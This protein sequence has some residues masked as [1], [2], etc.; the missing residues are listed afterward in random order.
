MSRTIV[1]VCGI[2]RA[3]DAAYAIACGADW[4]GFVVKAPGSPRAIA[5]EAAGGI[6]A[7]LTGT[8]AVAVMVAPTPDEAL[9]I[10]R[11][12]GATRVQLHRVRPADWPAD[13]PLP[14]AFG[15]GVTSTGALE[16]EVPARPH[17]VLLDTARAGLDG[18]T[19]ET[20]PWNAA[21]EIAS[22]RPV[23][24]AG[25]LDGDNVARAIVALRPFGVDASSRLEQSPGIKDPER[26]RRFVAAVRECDER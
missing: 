14:C 2:T 15:V 19:G 20:F 1:K 3:V 16:G 25:G 17:L 12:T 9:A 7:A 5:P 22:D 13:F 24:V 6:V 26:V 21:R 8:V 4:L 11:T 18:G 23:L 10:A